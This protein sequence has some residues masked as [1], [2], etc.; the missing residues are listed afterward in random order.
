MT[1]D[2]AAAREAVSRLESRPGRRASARW[3]TSSSATSGRCCWLLLGGA[4][5]LL[6][7]RLRQRRRACCWCAPRAAARELAVRSALGAS[8]GRLIRQ[9]VTE[10]LVLV[11]SAARSAL[12]SPAGRCSCSPASFPPTCGRRMP[13]LDGLGM[14]ARVV[15]VRR[16]SSRCVA[17]VLFSLAPA[18]A[19]SRV[20]S[21]ARAWPRAAAAPSGHTWRRL[22]FKLV[23]LELATAMVLL[24]GAGLLG[25]SLY[26]LLNVDLG[27][28]PDRLAT[29][30]VGAPG[31][32]FADRRAGGRAR[33]AR[34]CAAWRACR[35]S[36]SV[37]LTSVLPVSFNG[38]TDWIRFVGRPYN[39]EHNEVNQRDVSAGYFATLGARSCCAAATSPTPRTRRSRGRRSSTRRWRRLYFPGRGSDRQ[40]HRRHRAVARRRSR[41]SSASSTTSGKARSTRRSGRPCTTRSTQSPDTDVLARGA[42]GAA[43]PGGGAGAGR[44]DPRDRSRHRRRSARRS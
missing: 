27:F 44:R 32:R 19:P 43:E 2:R 13:F 9:F 3:P 24:V 6:A 14:N 35:A 15:A 8:R 39:G 18:A 33:R 11:G 16:R 22:G 26:R 17:I 37:G 30:Q 40:A 10:A 42:N 31:A 25:K 5:L 12:A 36:Q 23:V 28:E 7:D 1:V 41:R 34:S 29:L 21:C 20:A 38:N 4:A